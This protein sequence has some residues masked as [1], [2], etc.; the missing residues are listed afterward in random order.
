MQ[1]PALLCP[2]VAPPLRLQPSIRVL[3]R[4]PACESMLADAAESLI[5]TNT[6]CLAIFPIV[7]GVPVLINEKTSI[8]RIRDFVDGH[9]TTSAPRPKLIEMLDRLMPS[10]CVNTVAE[11]NYARFRGLLA[12]RDHLIRPRVLVIGAGVEGVGFQALRSQSSLDLVETD[13]S[14][15]ANISVVLDAHDIPFCD[16]TFDGIIAQAVLEHV[17]DPYRCVAEIW[18]VLRPAGAVYAETPFMQQAHAVP[19]DFT[20]FTYLGHRRLFRR[21]EEVDSGIATGPGMALAW[22][23]YYFLRSFAKS[24]W[25]RRVLSALGQLTGF[26]VKYFDRFVLTNEAAFDAAAGYFF[27]GRKSDQVLSDSDLLA[28]FRGASSHR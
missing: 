12:G 21:F 27:M 23:Y 11:A 17:L 9:S 2:P 14:I 25:T 16:E 5:C 10:I 18:R 19:Y 3:L 6:A 1:S 15:A 24:T 22:A 8:F 7:N 4:C 28:S 26:W 13:V 20:R